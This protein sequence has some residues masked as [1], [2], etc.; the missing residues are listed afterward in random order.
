ASLAMTAVML[1]WNYLITPIYMNYPRQ[2]VVKLLLPAF[3][4]FNLLKSGI[5]TALVLILYK[6]VV[7]ALRQTKMISEGQVKTEKKI[8]A[9]VA[10]FSVFVLITCVLVVMVMNKTI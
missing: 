2:A 4:P 7:A 1:L 3:L 5:N 8:N 9:G 6:P 10:F